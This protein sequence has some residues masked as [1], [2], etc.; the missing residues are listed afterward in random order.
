MTAD[1]RL[2]GYAAAKKRPRG[3]QRNGPVSVTQVPAEAMRVARQ[4]AKGKGDTVRIRVLSATCVLVANQPAR[5]Q[6]ARYRPAAG[7]ASRLP[8]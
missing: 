7:R 1:F 2:H 4:L 3:A 8:R 6:A 5:G